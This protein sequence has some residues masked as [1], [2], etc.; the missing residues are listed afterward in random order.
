MIDLLAAAG[1]WGAAAVTIGVFGW[2]L[3]DL[4]ACGIGELSPA[5]LVEPVAD[6]GRSGGIGPILISTLLLLVVCAFVALPI[7]VASGTWLAVAGV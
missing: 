7:G 5:F 3:L 4:L 6:A 1:V 2:I